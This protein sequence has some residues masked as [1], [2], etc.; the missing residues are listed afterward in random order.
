MQRQP[1]NL[2]VIHRIRWVTPKDLD[3]SRITLSSQ[4]DSSGSGLP[5]SKVLYKY[6]DSHP[7]ELYLTIPRSPGG[8]VRFMGARPEKSNYESKRRVC[9]FG[10]QHNN[11][12]HHDLHAAISR[13]DKRISEIVKGAP[14]F[15][16]KQISPQISLMYTHL[17]EGGDSRV[18]SS[19]YTV[20]EQLDITSIQGGMVRPAFI[21]SVTTISKNKY[22]KL[23]IQLAQM[24]I[25]ELSK[26]FPLATK[27]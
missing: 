18:Y 14:S 17:I 16:V 24:Y 15:A 1:D 2:P 9:T 8:Y 3:T 22:S 23:R 27:D 13:I 21:F 7:S 25:H 20:D 26:E 12:V 5:I 19:A 4:I 11:P 10:L 6:D